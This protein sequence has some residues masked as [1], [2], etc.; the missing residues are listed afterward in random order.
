VPP[1]LNLILAPG[2]SSSG[3]RTNSS[4]VPKP[5]GSPAVNAAKP[6]GTTHR[7]GRAPSNMPALL[8]GTSHKFWIHRK[9]KRRAA[10]SKIDW[11][12]PEDDEA[13]PMKSRSKDSVGMPGKVPLTTSWASSDSSH[14]K[15][16]PLSRSSRTLNDSDGHFC[17]PKQRSARNRFSRYLAPAD[18]SNCRE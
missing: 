3:R 8:C 11:D 18:W 15:W 7:A 10:A 9:A 4:P 14:Q 1:S 2:D 16:V 6:S 12:K 13:L 5:S 17:S